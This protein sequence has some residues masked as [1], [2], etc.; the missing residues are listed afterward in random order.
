MDPVSIT[1]SVTALVTLVAQAVSLSKRYVDGVRKSAD[2]ALAFVDELGFLSSNLGRLNE[3]LEND[4]SRASSFGQTSLLMTHTKAIEKKIQ[5]INSKLENVALSRLRQAIWP[6]TEKEHAEAMKELRIFSQW[7]HFSLSIDSSALL[8][9]TSEDVTAMLTRQ[10]QSIQ[11]LDSIETS[12]AATAEHLAMQT[13]MLSL[14]YERDERDKILNWLSIYDHEERHNEV[15]ASR[16]EN[17]GSWLLDTE[18]FQQWYQAAEAAD[19]TLWCY[20]NQ[21]S[22][23]SILT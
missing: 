17:T 9:Q 8:L 22:G 11:R 6:F 7:I 12:N 15:R 18:T 3:F 4:T 14:A 13:N 2:A 16:T 21:G 10:L 5:S 1:A 20:G 19:E 23:K